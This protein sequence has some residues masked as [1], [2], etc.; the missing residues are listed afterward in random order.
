MPSVDILNDNQETPLDLTA[1][2]GNVEIIRF[3]IDHGANL[4]VTDSNGSTPLHI[5]SQSGQLEA[6]KLLLRRGADIG[7]VNKANQTAAELTSENDQVEV[8]SFLD[9]YGTDENVRKRVWSTT[10]DTSHHGTD[11]D[12]K[13]KANASLLAASDEEDVELVKSTLDQGADTMPE[14]Q[15]SK[16]RYIERRSR[17]MSRL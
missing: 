16:P 14:I 12:E 1:C 17:G 8:A 9:E 2:E 4:H 5:A 3:L 15:C 11:D 13:D 6:V 10:L 7:L